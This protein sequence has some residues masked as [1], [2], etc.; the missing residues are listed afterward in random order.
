MIRR[1]QYLIFSGIFSA[2]LAIYVI[3]DSG[4]KWSV[5]FFSLA[6]SLFLLLWSCIIPGYYNNIVKL[7]GYFDKKPLYKL[8]LLL[9]PLLIYSL[10]LANQ[11]EFWGI[12]IIYFIIYISLPAILFY[13]VGKTKGN[14]QRIIEILAA[15]ALW[16][17]FDHRYYILF[18]PGKFPHE[19]NFTSLMVVLM[20]VIL[21]LII[22]KQE[23][24]GYNFIPGRKDFLLIIILTAVISGIIIPLGVITGFLKFKTNIKFE[25]FHIL[26]FIG[27]F[28]TIGLVEEVIFRGIIQNLLEKIFKSHL[29]A[30][31]IASV[32]F[33]MTHWNNA[34]PG[35]ALHYIFF[36]SIAGIF[37]GTAYKKSGSLFPAIFV[38]ALV[39]TLWLALFIK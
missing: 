8:L 11:V 25:F 3:L 34:D 4:E 24:I 33:G 19:Y 37:Y 38:H 26:A 15:I 7:P 12:H 32:L 14:I 23:D 31:L 2:L 21:F 30:L 36:A 17:P 35:F 1:N 18:W 9:Y 29:P 10:S 16:I 39:D 28:L 22:K 27:I 6:L 5:A 20:I 13:F